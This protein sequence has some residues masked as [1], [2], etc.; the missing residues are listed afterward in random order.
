M[1][2]FLLLALVWTHAGVHIVTGHLVETRG[3]GGAVLELNVRMGTPPRDVRLAV[4]GTHGEL[5]MREDPSGD[6]FSAFRTAGGVADLVHIGGR[7]FTLD[8]IINPNFAF[9][10]CPTCD[11]VLGIGGGSP[12]WLVWRHIEITPRGLRLAEKADRAADILD[13]TWAT[14]KQPSKV[15]CNTTGRVLGEDVVVL[16]APEEPKTILPASVFRALRDGRTLQH[17][18]PD[19]VIDLDAKG[20]L[21]ARGENLR[22]RI[23]GRQVVR[24]ASGEPTTITVRAMDNEIEEP[25]VMQ[26]VVLGWETLRATEFLRDFNRGRFAF[27]PRVVER[28][29]TFVQALTNLAFWI[30]FFYFKLRR[31][32]FRLHSNISVNHR[33]AAICYMLFDTCAALA[34]FVFFWQRGTWVVFSSDLLGILALSVVVLLSSAWLLLSVVFLLLRAPERWGVFGD[35]LARLVGSHP[36]PRQ[37]QKEMPHD[38]SSLALDLPTRIRL[39]R[40]LIVHD[41]ARDVSILATLWFINTATAASTLRDTMLFLVVVFSLIVA[42]GNPLVALFFSAGMCSPAW[43]TASVSM[44]AVLGAAATFFCVRVVYPWSEMFSAI[45]SLQEGLMTAI[46]LLTIANLMLFFFHGHL[47]TLRLYVLQR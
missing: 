27:A 28:N 8:A 2:L 9:S 39:V 33:A 11:G 30:A 47:R 15:F 34:P 18:W 4:D 43:L 20:V 29:M 40:A 38:M 25:G 32:I 35:G 42:L 46:S 16:I 44:W 22:L 45:F 10:I 13:H 37:R 26:T 17:P 7:H 6:S 5:V 41:W 31:P 1:L 36:F 21:G 19:L 23:P 3:I 24:D 12:L 14:C